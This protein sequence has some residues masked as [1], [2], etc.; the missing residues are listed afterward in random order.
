VGLNVTAT[1]ALLALGACGCYMVQ[2][3]WRRGNADADALLAHDSAFR[4]L[5]SQGWH[6]GSSRWRCTT[7][8]PRSVRYE[9]AHQQATAVYA[10]CED[11]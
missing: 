1:Y 9:H 2:P 7:S 4:A 10:V 11:A 5:P 6:M 3:G 8:R